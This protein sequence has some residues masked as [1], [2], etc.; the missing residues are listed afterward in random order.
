M[1]FNHNYSYAI[2]AVFQGIQCSYDDIMCGFQ[3]PGRGYDRVGCGDYHHAL[4]RCSHG[5]AHSHPLRLPLWF[6]YATVFL[7][8]QSIG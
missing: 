1:Y 4:A 6:W 8:S 3:I 5:G 7:P 2:I